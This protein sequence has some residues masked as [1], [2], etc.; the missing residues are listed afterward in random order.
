MIYYVILPCASTELRNSDIT[1]YCSNAI[2]HHD[3]F[4]VKP[5][6]LVNQMLCCVVVKDLEALKKIKFTKGDDIRLCLTNGD[7]YDNR[8][9]SFD[10]RNVQNTAAMYQYLVEQELNISHQ[11]VYV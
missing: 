5:P 3:A 10:I 11:I 2:S 6:D 7:K 8:D 4:G 1:K 9:N